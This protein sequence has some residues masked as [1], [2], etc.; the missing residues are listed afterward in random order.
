MLAA[1]MRLQGLS[2]AASADAMIEILD[3]NNNFPDCRAA[4]NIDSSYSKLI[5]YQIN[6]AK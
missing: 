3:N 4:A 1:I 5:H 6:R 2:R